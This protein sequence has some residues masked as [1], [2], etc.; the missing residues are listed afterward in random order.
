MR[1]SSLAR[2]ATECSV[3]IALACV[4]YVSSKRAK[5]AWFSR[6]HRAS[7]LVPSADLPY[8]VGP[9]VL[10]APS[11]GSRVESRSCFQNWV[12]A[13]PGADMLTFLTS[14]YRRLVVGV[15]P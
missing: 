11:P 7:V 10:L 13:S 1:S 9:Q 15:I 12:S 6:S 8:R 2:K 3:C 5:S 14:W 4:P